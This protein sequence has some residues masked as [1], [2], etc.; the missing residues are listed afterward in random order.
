LKLEIQSSL[1]WER[2]DQCEN[3]KTN[4]CKVV[5]SVAAAST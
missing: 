3:G 4:E 2:K 1:F 5:L